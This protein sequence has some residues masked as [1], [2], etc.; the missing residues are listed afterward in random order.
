MNYDR[1]FHELW[2]Q[3]EFEVPEHSEPLC[4]Y[5]EYFSEYAAQVV[6]DVEAHRSLISVNQGVLRMTHK[7]FD[8]RTVVPKSHRNRIGDTGH[9]CIFH[10]FEAAYLKL[11]M[12]ELALQPPALSPPP[13]PPP[14]PPSPR[15]LQIAGIFLG[16][17]DE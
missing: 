7:Y 14:P 13:P 17:D 4:S 6:A 15:P 9:R 5:A 8:W 11:K 3:A 10:V 16:E 2:N 1:N 12:L